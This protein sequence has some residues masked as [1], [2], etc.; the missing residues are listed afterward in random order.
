M[1]KAM[2][3]TTVGSLVLL[4]GCAGMDTGSRLGGQ[5]VLEPYDYD[6]PANTRLP[7]VAGS[8]I[9]SLDDADPPV[10]G[11]TDG[12]RLP[13]STDR[14]DTLTIVQ[15]SLTD[16]GGIQPFAQVDLPT[17]VSGP[18]DALTLSPDGT[19]ALALSFDLDVPQEIPKISGGALPGTAV[20]P[21]DLTDPLNPVIGEKY[22]LA[23]PGVMAVAIHPDGRRALALCFG[24]DEIHVLNI[25][26]GVITNTESWPLLIDTKAPYHPTSIQWH[27]S[28]HGFAVSM[29]D[30]RHLALFQFNTDG[31]NGMIKIEPWGEP[32]KTG[33]YPFTVRFSPDGR[34][35]YTTELA[36]SARTGWFENAAAG[37]IS[38]YQVDPIMAPDAV[39]EHLGTVTVG[40]SPTSIDIS[41]DGS[42]IAVGCMEGGLASNPDKPG[43]TSTGTLYLLRHDGLGGFDILTEVATEV[44]P[45]GVAFSPDGVHLFVA[46]YDENII[47]IWE[48]QQ[49][50]GRPMLID[51]GYGI[52]PGT[53]PH[54][55]AVIP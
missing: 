40:R 29:A 8:Y 6:D 53:G 12:R 54:D 5:R 49:I 14:G 42:L 50:T 35:I 18:I 7:N 15:L 32:I 43:A 13:P 37:Y 48:V 33:P 41:P 36:W 25:E 4:S 26:D 17:T 20:V 9:I 55:I 34:F 30:Y 2:L 24:S 19:L 16:A 44:M 51:T 10:V 23:E 39:H 52:E 21:I 45:A 22:D 3:F 27:P 28:G 46:G 47:S 11:Y 1:F 31:E 38:V